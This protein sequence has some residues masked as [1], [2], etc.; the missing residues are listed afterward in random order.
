MK[1]LPVKTIKLHS[2]HILDALIIIIHSG[3]ELSVPSA[4]WEYENSINSLFEKVGLFDKSNWE[5][6]SENDALLYDSLLNKLFT[7]LIK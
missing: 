2:E 5:S 1:K 4:Y 3:V 6:K 7:N